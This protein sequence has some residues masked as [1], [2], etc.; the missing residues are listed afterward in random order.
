MKTVV[1]G[2]IH[3]RTIWKE[4]V[5]KEWDADTVIFVGDYFDSFEIPGIEQLRNFE[6]IVKYKEESGKEVIMLIGNHDLHYF[7]NRQ[8][9]KMCYAQDAFLFSHAGISTRWLKRV[10]KRDWNVNNVVEKVNELFLTKPR[11][12]NF[13]DHCL[14][15]Y[16]DDLDQTPVWIRPLSLKIANR[17]TGLYRKYTQVVGHT[18]SRGIEFE[19][20]T[21]FVDTFDTGK[22]Y[23]TIVD[24]KV[25][26]ASL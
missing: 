20:R 9:L 23:L 12:F 5:Y 3:G 1:L 4:I 7:E 14:N 16:G 13:P 6:D 25:I 15:P 10:F 22:E 11:L 17:N 18:S 2:D 19:A 8:H 26:L 24:G 21:Y